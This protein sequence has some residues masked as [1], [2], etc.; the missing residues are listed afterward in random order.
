MRSDCSACEGCQSLGILI[1]GFDKSVPE[2]QNLCIAMSSPLAMLV[3]LFLMLSRKERRRLLSQSIF[4][5]DIIE[6]GSAIM[7]ETL[8]EQYSKGT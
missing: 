4:V 6:K 2:M 1:K 8:G 5:V 7:L 3:C